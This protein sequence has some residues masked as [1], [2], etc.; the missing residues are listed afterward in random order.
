MSEVH[1]LLMKNAELQKKVDDHPRLIQQH[2]QYDQQKLI[3]LR[4][5]FEERIEGIQNSKKE[6]IRAYKA[7]I[8]E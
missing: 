2:D 1:Q 8:E 6:E 5:E 7:V 4:K 3:T